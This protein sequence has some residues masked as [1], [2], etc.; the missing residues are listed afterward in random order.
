MQGKRERKEE[1]RGTEGG[2]KG[3]KRRRED[4]GRSE[5]GAHSRP[6][7]QGSL[8]GREGQREGRKK[9]RTQG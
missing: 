5:T 2:G 7:G 3:V 4:V 9:E 1:K 8:G 6:G